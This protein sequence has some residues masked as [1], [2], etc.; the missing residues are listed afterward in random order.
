[1]K[2]LRVPPGSLG[3]PGEVKDGVTKFWESEGW[4]YEAIEGSFGLS[5][6]LWGSEGWCDEA[7]GQ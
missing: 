7:L 1:M 3:S 5:W 2:A 4:C 6:E